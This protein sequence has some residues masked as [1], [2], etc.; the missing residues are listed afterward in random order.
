MIKQ[1]YPVFVR[2]ESSV[3]ELNTLFENGWFLNTYD[4]KDLP[5]LG[6]EV[7]LSSIV[8]PFVGDGATR[9]PGGQRNVLMLM[10]ERGPLGGRQMALEVRP[11]ASGYRDLEFFEKILRRETD[12]WAIMGYLAISKTFMLAIIER[13][14]YAGR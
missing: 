4:L 3:G 11:N 13:K 7:P 10:L 12:E 1:W 9:G 5:F 14:E 2:D 8:A 6:F